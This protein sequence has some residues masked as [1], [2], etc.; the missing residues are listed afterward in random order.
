MAPIQH[1]TATNV[2]ANVSIRGSVPR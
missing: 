1:G 2:I